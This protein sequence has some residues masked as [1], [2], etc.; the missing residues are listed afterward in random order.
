M[1]Q[2][3]QKILSSHGV[4]SR[5]A[6]EAL[7]EAGR[8][9]VNG[10]VAVLGESAEAE[11]DDIRLDG[12]PLPPTAERIYIMLNKPRGYVTTLSDE[13]GRKTVAELT[14][15]CPARVYPVGRLDMDSD[16]L[17]LLTN[18]GEFAQTLMHPSHG[19]AKTYRVIAGGDIASALPIL[20]APITLDGREV[21]ASEVRVENGALI[22]SVTEGRNRLVRR[23]CAAAGLR[24][25][26]LT[27]ISEGTLKIGELPMGK[28]R[29]LT[30]RELSSIYNA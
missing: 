25:R 13:R 5:R 4:A 7:I 21:L 12:K 18:D 29:Y 24:V 19:I 23:M 14:A 30:P 8:V 2:R 11:R 10:R 22:I 16:G 15:D 1:P 17:L 27:R 3:L 28:W 20:Q 9:T 6:A 26:R